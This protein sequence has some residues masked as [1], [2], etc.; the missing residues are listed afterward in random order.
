MARRTCRVRSIPACRSPA[1]PRNPS[2][3][4]ALCRSQFL[5]RVG[6]ATDASRAS[7]QAGRCRPKMS[8]NTV[9]IAASYEARRSAFAR[10]R[11]SLKQNACAPISSSSRPATRSTL[12]TITAWSKQLKAAFRSRP[13][14]P[15]TKWPVVTLGL[16]SRLVA[17][18]PVGAIPHGAR[19][20]R[21]PR[22]LRHRLLPDAPLRLPRLVGRPARA[23]RAPRDPHALHERQRVHPPGGDGRPASGSS[24]SPPRSWAPWA[25][26]RSGSRSSCTRLLNLWIHSGRL[27]CPSSRCARSRRSCGTTTPTTSRCKSGYY[28]SITLLWDTVSDGAAPHVGLRRGRRRPGVTAAET[29]LPGRLRRRVPSARRGSLTA[30]WKSASKTSLSCKMTRDAFTRLKMSQALP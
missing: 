3:Q 29:P 21:D 19:A 13:S 28:A 5:L 17:T 24:S 23:R 18:H 14:A 9:C 10:A 1:T 8:V 26:G 27:P 25:S 7:W 15:S 22:R 20:H 16:S 6:R 2:R 4:L 11:W 30:P 12:T